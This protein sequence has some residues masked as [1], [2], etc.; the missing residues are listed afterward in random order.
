MKKIIIVLIVFIF[1]IGCD[2]EITTFDEVIENN[3][4]ELDGVKYDIQS[5]YETKYEYDDEKLI[6]R[7][8]IYDNQEQYT[9]FKYENSLLIEERRYSVNMNSTVLYY[10]DDEKRKKQIVYQYEQANFVNEF[11]YDGNTIK[12]VFKNQDGNIE[13]YNEGFVD[14]DDNI[15]SFIVYDSGGNKVSSVE[16]TYVDNKLITV[17]GED[18][19]GKK[20]TSYYKYNNVG[21]KIFSYTIHHGEKALMI[22]EFFEYNY[23]KNDLPVM[24]KRYRVQSEIS[25]EHIRDYW[26]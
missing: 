8:S 1:L 25:Q 9:E 16:N 3:Q 26:N 19:E 5:I 21:D 17:I 10:Y 14:E 11:E 4:V 23:S 18:S 6:R 20:I 12:I 24:M 7:S 2:K 15:L 22:A 13:R